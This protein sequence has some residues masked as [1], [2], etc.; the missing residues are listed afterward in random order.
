MR[1]IGMTVGVLPNSFFPLQVVGECREDDEEDDAELC[2]AAAEGEESYRA[3]LLPTSAEHYSD[4][5]TSLS[6]RNVGESFSD[7]PHPDC[8]RGDDATLRRERTSAEPWSAASD[9][10]SSSGAAYRDNR[11]SVLE[12]SDSELL[13]CL[14]EN[15]DD[16]WWLAGPAYGKYF[17]R[18][19]H[20]T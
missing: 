19:A 6:D 14:V 15:L 18:K 9:V 17:T 13:D 12:L 3:T 2:R 10:Q 5:S 16:E 8:D 11:G 20:G 1:K 4:P 7:T